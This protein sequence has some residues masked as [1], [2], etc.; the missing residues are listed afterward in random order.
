MTSRERV[1]SALNGREVDRPPVFTTMTPQAARKVSDHLGLPYEEPLDSLLSTRISHM[2]LLTFLG[3]DCVGISACAPNDHPTRK[4]D[5]GL[6]ENEWGMVF[7]DIGLYNEFAEYPLAHAKT[8][9][10]I[11]NY[12]FPDP[13]A[14]GRYEEA[15]KTV[16]K[17]GDHYAIVGDIETSFWETSWYLVGL[18][19]LMM[20]LMME[21]PYVDVLFDRVMEINLEIGR[22]LIRLGADILW[23]GDDF[24]SQQAMLLDPLTWRRYFKP[25]MRYMIGEWRK[26]N[27][28]IK[29]AWHTC[30]SVIPIIDDFIEIGIDLLNPMQPLAAGMDAENVKRLGG[31]RIM[32][33]G[34]IDIQ[35][36]LPNG[37]V[38]K[39]KTEVQRIAGIYGRHKNYL[40]APAHNIQDDTPVEHILTFFEA[41]REMG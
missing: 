3:N 27:P 41:V 39:I 13:H 11:D 34:G 29:I 30:G 38:E 10:D 9:T 40:L 17:Y 5:D 35:E 25:R 24:G 1:I 21:T 31:E 6:I 15:K 22:Q 7:K 4:R 36:L 33:F 26:V 19:K 8:A 32:Y 28:E 14:A 2:D 18:E 37:P 20:D 12:P 23:A 16:M